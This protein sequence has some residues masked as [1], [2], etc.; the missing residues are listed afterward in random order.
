MKVTLYYINSDTDHGYE[1]T[2]HADGLA[3]EAAMRALIEE[4]F[5]DNGPRVWPN[6]DSGT[7]KTIRRLLDKNNQADL[8]DAWALWKEEQAKGCD[9]Y[10]A[11]SQEIDITLPPACAPSRP[12][13]S[14]APRTR[15][16]TPSRNG[17]RRRRWIGWGD[18]NQKQA[19]G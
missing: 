13:S 17:W 5:K 8:W 2:F 1:T 16:T 6:E 3:H 14:P 4:S 15:C 18:T 10:T 7:W 12:T 11:N 19:V 9:Y